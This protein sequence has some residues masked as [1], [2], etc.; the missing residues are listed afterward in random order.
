[1]RRPGAS[2]DT[3]RPLIF[4]ALALVGLFWLFPLVWALFSS[5]KQRSDLFGY[6]PTLIP[7]DPTVLNYVSLFERYPFVS[8]FLVST[9]IA[10]VSTVITVF[11]CSLAGFGFAKYEFRGKRALFDIM[12]S[13]MAIPFAVIVVPLFIML[14][15]TGLA[16][17]WF[18]L[19]VP[20]VAPAFGIFMMRQFSE[21]AIP[22]E[23]LNAARIDGAGEFTIFRSIVA[24]L[25]RPGLGALAVWSFLNAYNNFLWPLIVVGDPDMYTLPLGLQAIFGAEGRQYDIVL[26][27]SI[28]AA[29][30]SVIVFIAL[31]K[32]LIDG[33]AAGA[34]KS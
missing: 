11:V 3:S 4:I 6:P 5:F 2:R 1:M 28:L 13:S 32:Q 14:A 30:P 21:Q 16:Q 19:I 24:P 27:G 25:L 31:R 7:A 9:V 23:I 15:K 26:A 22:D 12:F 33:L 29:I 20:W 17:P 34:V 18:A 10:V 8:W